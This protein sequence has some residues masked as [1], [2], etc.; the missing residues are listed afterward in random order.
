MRTQIKYFFKIVISYFIFLIAARAA[1]GTAT[2]IGMSKCFCILN[3]AM[4][5]GPHP[6]MTA[7]A[8]SKLIELLIAAMR[9]ASSFVGDATNSFISPSVTLT[10]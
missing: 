8:E 3:P 7:P 2:S 6:T 10:P 1:A 4:E 5:H 9:A